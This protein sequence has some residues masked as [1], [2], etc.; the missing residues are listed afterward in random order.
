M[1]AL[2][3]GGGIGGLATALHLHRSGVDV[4][5]FEQSGG[6]RELGVG[7]NLLPPAVKQ[8]VGFG[9]GERLSASAVSAA[10]LIYAHRLGQRIWSEPRGTEAGYDV[11]Q[12]SIHRGRLQRI[13]HDAVRER[14][15]DAA[16]RTGCRLTGFDADDDGVTARFASGEDG[17]SVAAHGDILVGADGIHSTTRALL[18]PD[19][20]PPNWNGVI[21]WRGATEWPRFLT[22]RSVVIAGGNDA[23]LVLYPIGPGRTA[24]TRLTNWAVC[25]R[26]GD[27]SAPP[28]QRQDW[29]RPGRRA[30]LE[31]HLPLFDTP[32]LDLAGLVAA[33]E[34]FFEF[35]MCDRDPLPYWS[36][37]RVTLLGDAAHPMYPM[38]SNGAGQAFMDA[39][40]LARHLA[41]D[42]DPVAALRAYQEERLPVTAEIVRANR[43]GGPER[44]ID[45]VEK[46]AP[47]GF[48]RIEDVVD[49]AELAAIVA[50]YAQMSG[51]TRQQV[52]SAFP[53]EEQGVQLGGVEEEAVGQRG[54][55]VAGDLQGHDAVQAGPHGD[56][57]T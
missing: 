8:L 46:R 26:T 33:T 28:P 9:L 38:G 29:S 18:F 53:G 13:L 41:A 2:V 20:G 15:G 22:G 43:R 50:N 10:E 16:V 17:G 30:D 45:E 48:D 54:V 49:P 40:A 34:E 5:V 39:E 7:L 36:T 55:E 35:P 1:K 23:K 21:M 11:P 32:H 25:V 42:T 24:E 14:L 51:A 19:E 47:A 37:G 6:I 3:I 57:E 4:E 27:G 56:G 44:V 31:P 12:Y 52:N